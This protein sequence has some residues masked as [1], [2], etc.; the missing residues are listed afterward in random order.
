MKRNADALR[1][2]LSNSPKG[3]K[4]NS[5]MLAEKKK[6]D[7]LS[8]FH[9]AYIPLSQLEPMTYNREIYK[10][11][12]L[13][14]IGATIKEFGLIQEI[15][16]QKIQGEDKY[17][18]IAGERRYQ[19]IILE[20]EKSE[21]AGE[22]FTLYPKGIPC[23]LFPE[24]MPLTKI[25]II[26]IIAN[27]T[28]RDRDT[29]TQL[30][31]IKQLVKEYAAAEEEG[32]EIGISLKS[33]ILNRM[34]VKERQYQK[35]M[36]ALKMLPEFQEMLENGTL[37]MDQASLIGSKPTEIQEEIL[38]LIQDNHSI[39]DAINSVNRSY[40]EYRTLLQKQDE[41][42]KALKTELRDAKSQAS[43]DTANDDREVLLKKIETLETT[44]AKQKEKKKKV[45]TGAREYIRT[46]VTPQK[47]TPVKPT[48]SEEERAS[49]NL[50]LSSA[51]Q[52]AERDL[53]SIMMALSRIEADENTILK[54]KELASRLNS[55]IQIAENRY[56]NNS[57]DFIV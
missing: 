47:E 24:D 12:D 34:N 40:R 14:F 16:V 37:N 20:K 33:L 7:E 38:I 4:P 17:R 10:I 44:L 48:A 31:E 1:N 45:S 26:L 29:G 13:D 3:L 54:L 57:S 55:I 5:D 46:N 51:L 53:S 32:L 15:C 2:A 22:K 18:I 42:I 19:S 21:K 11:D 56:Q 50:N 6:L 35:Y 9:T 41:T 52:Y 39:D 49:F 28:S 23:R 8:S 25:K 27:A 36:A 30:N 43:E